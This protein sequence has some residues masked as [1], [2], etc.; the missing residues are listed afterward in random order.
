MK[1]CTSL[2]TTMGNTLSASVVV[3]GLLAGCAVTP[4]VV[5][6]LPELPAEYARDLAVARTAP[7]LMTKPVAKPAPPIES[8]P[9]SLAPSKACTS[10]FDGYVIYPITVCQPPTEFFE[11]LDLTLAQAPAPAPG[12]TGV[13]PVKYFKL[14]SHPQVRFGLPFFCT[15]RGGPWYAHVEGAQICNV[16]PNTR[17]FKAEILGAPESVVVTWTGALT[18]VPPPLNLTGI[19]QTGEFC[20]C[21]SGVMCP[22]GNCVPNINQCGVGP[23]ALRQ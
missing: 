14:T 16:N 12:K 21:C 22:S 6:D 5:R 19:Q 20:S 9:V 4:N 8:G 10:V 23:P 2:V 7:V 15:V 1:R 18:D 17:L 3:C 11:S 13:L